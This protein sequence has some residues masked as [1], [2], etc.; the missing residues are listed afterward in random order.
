MHTSLTIPNLLPRARLRVRI[1]H[2][3]PWARVRPLALG[4][5]R[6]AIQVL[7]GTGGDGEARGEGVA[8]VLAGPAG[9]GVFGSD[10]VAPSSGAL[11]GRF[12]GPISVFVGCLPGILLSLAGRRISRAR[13]SSLAPSGRTQNWG[14]ER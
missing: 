7:E 5:L 2:V 1:H 14:P 3:L 4:R 8:A 10:V 13:A 11:R 9:S 12:W 6:R